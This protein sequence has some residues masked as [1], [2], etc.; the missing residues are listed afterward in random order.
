MTERNFTNDHRRPG[1]HLVADSG[2]ASA[3]GC[4]RDWGETE[5]MSSRDYRS[6]K[7]WQCECCNSEYITISRLNFAHE[8]EPDWWCYLVVEFLDR[9]DTLLDRIKRAASILWYGQVESGELML[10]EQTAREIAAELLAVADLTAGT[11]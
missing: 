6:E 5:K 4:V 11:N 2:A 10:D 8:G 9:S 1:R 7:R 3:G